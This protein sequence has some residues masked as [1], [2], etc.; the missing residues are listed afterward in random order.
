MHPVSPG[1]AAAPRHLNLIELPCYSDT[2]ITQ[3]SCFTSRHGNRV[4][5]YSVIR[6][7]AAPVPARCPSALVPPLPAALPLPAAAPMKRAGGPAA[8]WKEVRSA[9]AAAAASAVAAGMSAAAEGLAD[10]AATSYRPSRR[11]TSRC[12]AS[13]ASTASACATRQPC[14]GSS[15]EDRCR[16]LSPLYRGYVSSGLIATILQQAGAV[17]WQHSILEIVHAHL[18]PSHRS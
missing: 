9:A 14:Y 8:S 4:C 11:Q 13:T 7:Q 15:P 2:G 6:G 3:F 5:G 18:Q 10:S 16:R 1:H 17:C 12:T